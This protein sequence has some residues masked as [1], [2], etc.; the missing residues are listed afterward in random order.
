MSL[1]FASLCAIVQRELR[2][3][4]ERAA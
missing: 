2:V 4:S 3:G 1:E